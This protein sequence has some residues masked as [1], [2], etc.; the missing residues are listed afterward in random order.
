M[1]T[2]KDKNRIPEAT[3]RR[4]P[5]Y[6]LQIKRLLDEG[7]RYV[8]SKKLGEYLGVKGTQIRKD[9]SYF[10]VFGKAR[11]G[12]ETLSLAKAIKKI[13]GLTKQYKMVIVGAGNIGRALASYSGFH[14]CGF[15]VKYIFDV[16]E[17]KIGTVI[18]GV[19]VYDFDKIEQVLD[20]G[21]IDIAIISTP[22]DKALQAAQR[23]KENGV[24]A[25]YNFTSAELNSIEDA[26]IEDAEISHGIFKLAHRLRGKWPRK[27]ND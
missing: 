27:E 23:L 20:K 19:K 7:S 6:F 15:D 5:R 21:E 10:G 4:L 17:N 14:T 16:D 12:Y 24:H 22:E 25:F 1:K 9:L 26:F 13:L 8:S 3:M 2:T 18:S 11:Y